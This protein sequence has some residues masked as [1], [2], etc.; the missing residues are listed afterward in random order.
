MAN[1]LGLEPAAPVRERKNIMHQVVIVGGGFGGLETAQRLRKAD[2]NVTLIDRHNYHLFQPLLYQVA[3]GGLSPANIA[4]PLR[5]ILRRQKNCQVLMAEVTDFDI[6]NNR[7][8]LADGE[9]EYDTLVVAAGATHSYFGHDEWESFAPGLK[10]IEDAANIRRKIYLAFEAAERETDAEQRKAL[11]TFV[12]V[13]GGPTGVELAGALAEIADHTLRNDFRRIDP[14]EARILLVEAASH[15]LSHYPEDLCDF[16]AEKIRALGIELHTHT[17][18]T[19]I[20]ADEVQLMSDEQSITVPTKTVLWGAGVQANSLG[21]KLTN[22]CGIQ[23]D[24]AGHVP[25][26]DRLT[27]QG[28]DQIFAIGDIATCLS[29]DGKPLPGLAPVAMQQGV[30]VA[31]SI[32]ARLKGDS[33]DQPFVYRDRGTMATIGRAAAVAQVGK[34]HFCGLFAWLLWLFVHLMLIVQF[35]NRLLI[36]MQWAWCYGTF[37]RSNR[38]ILGEE[39]VALVSAHEQPQNDASEAESDRQTQGNNSPPR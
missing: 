36:L 6:A 2:V 31:Q 23:T 21:K 4:T 22:A 24:R 35:Q 33:V 37:N 1:L 26:T 28:Y 7:L 38:I 14:Q 27:V 10:S 9:L 15:V 19:A 18:V 13:G 11:M 29:A 34:R 8:L 17:K 3:T 20:T 16:A 5:S 32:I 39:H 25:V 12:I 30:Y